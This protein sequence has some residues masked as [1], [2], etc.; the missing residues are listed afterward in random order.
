VQFVSW[1]EIVPSHTFMGVEP[2]MFGQV[3]TPQTAPGLME[4]LPTL[5]GVWKAKVQS[6]SE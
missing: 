6:D 1:S 4:G 2:I 5:L 3:A